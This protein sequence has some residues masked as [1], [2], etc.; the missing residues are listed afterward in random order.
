MKIQSPGKAIEYPMRETMVLKTK[1]FN[2]ARPRVSAGEGSSAAP[3]NSSAI[4]KKVLATATGE[5]SFS[6][7][8]APLITL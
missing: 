7:K 2:S 1:S 5:I 6:P 4:A 8:E 3:L